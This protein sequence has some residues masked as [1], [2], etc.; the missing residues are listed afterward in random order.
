MILPIRWA[1]RLKEGKDSY[2]AIHAFLDHLGRLRFSDRTGHEVS[3]TAELG[4]KVPGYGGIEN[5]TLV[6]GERMLLIHGMKLLELADKVGMVEMF[7]VLA[8]QLLINADQADSDYR[9]AVFEN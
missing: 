7:A 8:P 9:D 1:N 5:A 2:H 4:A 3:S 6:Q